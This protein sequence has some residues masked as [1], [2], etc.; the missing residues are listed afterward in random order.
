LDRIDLDNWTAKEVAR[1]LTLVENDRRYYQ[2][3]LT[4]LPVAV[5]VVTRELS[6]VLVNRAFRSMF[7]LKHDDLADKRLDDL[8]PSPVVKERVPKLLDQN[9][10]E[11]GIAISRADADGVPKPCKLS[12]IPLWDPYHEGPS[13]A[14]VAITEVEQAVSP[15]AMI[16]DAL[17]A[18]AW[19]ADVQ[20]GELEFGNRATKQLL[21]AGTTWAN[22]VHQDDASRVAWVYE[23]AL[24]SGTEATVEYRAV[25][26][27]GTTSWFADRIRPVMEQGRVAA[28]HILTSEESAR[29]ERIRRLVHAREQDAAMRLA[30]QVAH[31]FNNLW[32]I[33][34]GYSEVVAE[35]LGTSDPEAR[36]SLEAIQ[37]AA[38]RGIASTSQLLMFGRPQAAHVQPL[39]LHVLLRGTQLPVELQLMEGAAPVSVDAGKLESA[40]RA[41]LEFVRGRADTD[42][43]PVLKT[44]LTTFI[45]DMADGLPRGKFVTLT[46][47]PVEKLNPRLVAHWCD[48]YFSEVG[49]TAPIGMALIYS[50]L[51]QMGVWMRLDPQEPD[52]GV[53]VLEF[54]LA[55]L[56]EPPKPEPEP[57][58]VAEPEKPPSRE[59][60][61]VVDDEESIRSLV[62]RVLTKHGYEV[63]EAATA[64]EAVRTSDEFSGDIPIVVS[65]VMLPG[66]RG[67]EMVKHLRHN[68]PDLRVLYVSGYTDDEVASGVLDAGEGF[69][70]KP[71]TLQSLTQ[72]VRAVLDAPRD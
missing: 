62:G 53:L 11:M 12:V 37:K 31:D 24:E 9:A 64:E 43:V 68:R 42:T 38:E 46:I 56:P 71:F 7:R 13:E 14:L 30:Q 45:S 4:T 44:G 27:D 49:K 28:L 8:M 72:T 66:M 15:G 5:A 57:V 20:T 21:G 34:N 52:R 69:L 36:S 54:P 70:Q 58:A 6:L 1:L 22:R 2:E 41:I 35:R 23:A 32:M 18:V 67:P 39:D 29:R 59:T 47:G 63:L 40:L 16:L 55:R 48:P 17:G 61:L 19:R 50:Q 51:R 3:I 60:V 26:S 65:D 25:R 10:P 33:V